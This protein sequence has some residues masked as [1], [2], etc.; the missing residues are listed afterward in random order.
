MRFVVLG[1][2]FGFVDECCVNVSCH[3]TARIDRPANLQL[4]KPPA[5]AIAN[6]IPDVVARL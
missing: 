5:L 6:C 2:F 1:P 4:T 3:L